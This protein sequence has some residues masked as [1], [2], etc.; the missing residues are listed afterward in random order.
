[1]H[2]VMNMGVIMPEKLKDRKTV[3]PQNTPTPDPNV[4]IQKMMAVY[5]QTFSPGEYL[6]IAI[7]LFQIQAPHVSSSFYT[8]ASEQ[9]ACFYDPSSRMNPYELYGYEINII[10]QLYHHAAIQDPEKY[11][12]FLAQIE[13]IAYD[14]H[15]AKLCKVL[16]ELMQQGQ[17]YQLLQFIGEN[18]SDPNISGLFSFLNDPDTDLLLGQLMSQFIQHPDDTLLHPVSSGKPIRSN[19]TILQGRYNFLRAKTLSDFS[20]ACLAVFLSAMRGDVT[21]AAAQMVS[22][23][24]CY[25]ELNAEQQAQFQGIVNMIEEASHTSNFSRFFTVGLQ[26]YYDAE[27]SLLSSASEGELAALDT[28]V[29]ISNARLEQLYWLLLQPQHPST[30]ILILQLA[31]RLID[32]QKEDAHQAQKVHPGPGYLHLAINQ[33]N[34]AYF[35]QMLEDQ[36]RTTQSSTD[37]GTWYLQNV[38]LAQEYHEYHARCYAALF[39]E[40]H[41]GNRQTMCTQTLLQYTN[42]IY[43]E[44]LCP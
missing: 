35:H 30:R 23:K 17:F 41:Q 24:D 10:Y 39:R 36:L 8:W 28:L 6:N 16:T 44:L 29:I 1:M 14:H 22:V 34:H 20:I 5:T 13:Q 27:P 2:Y 40:N 18:F 32:T 9:F 12:E 21:T 38:L 37:E 7:A 3:E 25:N 19:Y 4:L 11:G 26:A 43:Q 15:Q 42:P 31:A 33:L